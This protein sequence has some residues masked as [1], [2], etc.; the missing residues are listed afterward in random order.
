MCWGY[1]FYH[2]QEKN[3]TKEKHDDPGAISKLKIDKIVSWR[4][5]HLENALSIYNNQTI[6][7]NISKYIHGVDQNSNYL[8]IKS[9]IKPMLYEPD[10]SLVLL[11]NPSGKPII[12]TNPAEP[13]TEFD[14]RII[15]QAKL[16]QDIVF[17]DQLRYYDKTAFIDLAIPLYLNPERHEG[18]SGVVFLRIDPE[19][20]FYPLI[21]N[22]PTPIYYK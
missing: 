4:K 11:V 8:K 14:K 9:W 17:S 1:V 2:Y 10:F 16:S 18:L 12:N 5:E 15:E 13:V 22:W 3:N 20:F 7:T 6:I 21:L 19:K